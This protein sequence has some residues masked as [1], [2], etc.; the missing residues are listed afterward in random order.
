MMSNGPVA[1]FFLNL[2]RFTDSRTPH[3]VWPGIYLETAP[4]QLS[5]AYLGAGNR[6]DLLMRC[7]KG[8]HQ[9]QSTLNAEDDVGL[10][11]P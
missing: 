7:S 6:A 8:L 2:F 5:R 4:R 9:V 3:C 1:T 11:K 10:G